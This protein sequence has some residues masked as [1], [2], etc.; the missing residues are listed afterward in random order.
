MADVP[1]PGEL[2]SSQQPF[3]LPGVEAS[4][5]EAAGGG[6]PGIGTII[7]GALGGVGALVSGFMQQASAR[8][9]MRFQE[10]MSNTAHQR[11]VKDLRA[12]GLNPMLSATHGGASSPAG[13]QSQFP[14][15]GE[16][17][18]AGVSASA[19]MMALELPA[20]E[21]SIRL[22]AAQGE[23]A[24]TA[25]E[26]NRASAALSLAQAGAVSD[27]QRVKRATANR[28]EKL[29]EPEIGESLARQAQL[30]DQLHV[31]KA[32]AAQMAAETVNTKARKA[33]IDYES[34]SVN[35]NL[36]TA[37]RTV[38]IIGDLIPVGNTVRAIGNVMPGGP[39]SGKRVK[40]QIRSMSNPRE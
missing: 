31:Q 24:Y 40:E 12:A 15:V 34:S 11:E 38:G 18:G 29:T 33:L 5:G 9:Q 36:R 20:L 4:A 28:I 22:Q 7:G 26:S 39:S 8:E 1:A 19:K 32:S 37:E 10:R 35:T 23:A 3:V 6:F 2:G 30:R 21:S 16:D 17:L 25:G 27:D 13:A 14:N